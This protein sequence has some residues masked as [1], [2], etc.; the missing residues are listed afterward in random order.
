MIDVQT[1]E[2]KHIY[3]ELDDVV[4]GILNLV[5][6]TD[7]RL[8]TIRKRRTGSIESGVKVGFPHE[9]DYVIEVNGELQKI[10]YNDKIKFIVLT[11][12]P[13]IVN[14]AG[15]SLHAAKITQ[16]GICLW[17]EYQNES[18]TASVT[19]DLV[20]MQRCQTVRGLQTH[21]N[22]NARKYLGH[23]LEY[24]AFLYLIMK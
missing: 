18:S 15:W 10:I 7:P 21:L 9:T 23:D 1:E 4:E 24:F 12:S 13:P 11:N 3:D 6:A 5:R 17:L 20:S 14:K 8:L 19:V 22:E 16:P 2:Y